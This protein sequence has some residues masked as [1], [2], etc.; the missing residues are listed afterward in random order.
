L[1]G[2]NLTK[3]K[4]GKTNIVLDF[5][6][7]LGGGAGLPLG[8][9]QLATIPK[10]KKPHVKPM[11]LASVAYDPN[12]HMITL[13][14][15][16]SGLAAGPSTLILS[17][18]GASIVAVRGRWPTVSLVPTVMAARRASIS[19]AADAVD[20]VFLTPAP[21]A[22]MRGAKGEPKGGQG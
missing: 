18:Q 4:K 22:R 3:A 5:N 15:T 20:A 9:F 6:G 2:A 11:P 13:K 7:P 16:I 21:V 10:G 19:L 1:I 14:L 8:A 12:A 17:K